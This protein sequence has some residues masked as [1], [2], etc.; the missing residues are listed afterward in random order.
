MSSFCHQ[1][2][3]TVIWTMQIA[4]KKKFPFVFLPR[5]IYIVVHKGCLLVIFFVSTGLQYPTPLSAIGMGRVM[6]ALYLVN[7]KRANFTAVFRH[8]PTVIGEPRKPSL[9]RSSYSLA[10]PTP[11]C[12]LPPPRLGKV[13]RSRTYA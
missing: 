1:E 2:Q 13:R 12:R 4:F 11:V 7:P 6:V 10:R 8:G 5:P 3:L 9:D